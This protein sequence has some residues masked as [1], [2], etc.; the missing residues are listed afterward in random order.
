VQVIG[1]FID[2]QWC[3]KDGFIGGRECFLCTISPKM[4][5]FPYQENALPNILLVDNNAITFGLTK[6]GSA[7]NAGHLSISLWMFVFMIFISCLFTLFNVHLCMCLFN[8]VN[9]LEFRFI[10]VLVTSHLLAQDQRFT[11]Q[12]TGLH[13]PAR[14]LS[15][16]M[17]HS[18]G[19]M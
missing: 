6:Y 4:Q 12:Q 15:L 10:A 7:F 17:N 14:A 3:R 2:T 11:S 19:L 9:V 5:C 13:C 16:A 18:L 1:A 8:V